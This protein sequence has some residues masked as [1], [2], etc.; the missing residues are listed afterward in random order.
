VEALQTQTYRGVHSVVAL[1]EPG[2]FGGEANPMVTVTA[3]ASVNVPTYLIKRDAALDVSLSHSVAGL[4][5]GGRN[6][7]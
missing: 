4:G 3:L 7:R 6:L 1:V 2:T 5:R